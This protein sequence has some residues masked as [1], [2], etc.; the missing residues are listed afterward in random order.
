MSVDYVDTLG[1][2][3]LHDDIDVALIPAGSTFYAACPLD[4]S[5]VTLSVA[6]LILKV[7]V[8]KSTPRGLE[9]PSVTGV[10]INTD[11]DGNRT[12]A[13]NITNRYKT[14]LAS[15]AT[16]HIVYFDASGNIVDGEQSSTGAAIEPG[17]TVGFQFPI[18]IESVASAQ[19]SVDPCGFVPLVACSS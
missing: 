1:R 16:I 6:A 5:N 7:T 14:P 18:L 8:S 9:L 4:I 13:G 10:A 3:L 19:V 2:S 11:A 15:D 12:L 17:A